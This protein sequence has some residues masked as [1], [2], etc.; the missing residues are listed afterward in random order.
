MLNR[1]RRVIAEEPYEQTTTHDSRQCT[2]FFI[3]SQAFVALAESEPGPH[4][5]VA[6]PRLTRQ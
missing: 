6:T 1:L 3:D 2:V 4:Q 5:F